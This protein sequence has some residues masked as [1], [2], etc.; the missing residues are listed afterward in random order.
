MPWIGAGYVLTERRATRRLAAGLRTYC[1]V[2]AARGLSA[3]H[4]AG[5]EGCAPYNSPMRVTVSAEMIG[6]DGKC[7]V[8]GEPSAVA[9]TPESAPPVEERMLLDLSNG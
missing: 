9:S 5:G 4:R 1:P 3:G 6:R 8:H 7:M 2:C